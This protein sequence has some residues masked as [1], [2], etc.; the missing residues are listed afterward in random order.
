MQKE[1]DSQRVK[2]ISAFSLLLTKFQYHCLHVVLICK[3]W[4]KAYPA[5]ALQPLRYILL[6]C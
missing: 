4:A 5:F 1:V 3:W 6:A 2:A